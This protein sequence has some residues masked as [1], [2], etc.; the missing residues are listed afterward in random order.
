MT[1]ELGED[2]TPAAFMEA[3]RSF[4]GLVAEIT[5][6]VEATE[7]QHVKWVVKV[8]EGSALL[9]VEPAPGAPMPVVRGV[10]QKLAQ[11]WSAL[12]RGDFEQAGLSEIGVRH[13]RALSDLVI[14]RQYSPTPIKLWI[15]KQPV[16]VSAAPA[17]TIRQF[18]QI[19]YHDYGTAEGVLDAIRERNQLEITIYDA[20][21]KQ[22]MKCYV[23]EDLLPEA[24][25]N[26]RNRVEVHGL[27]HYRKDGTPISIDVEKIIPFEL[28]GSLPTA[29]DV[30]GI[31]RASV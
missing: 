17:N 21:L 11:S 12:E 6:A 20:P 25:A 19:D 16:D 31:L 3:A 28:E 30:R 13:A 27:I 9:G 1:L 18:M 14:G 24:M 15:E 4:F 22:R 2:L 5:Q 23:P 26:F 8:R 7:G 29:N 10:Y